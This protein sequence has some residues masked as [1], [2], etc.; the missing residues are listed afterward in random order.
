MEDPDA[1]N[2]SYDQFPKLYVWNKD[3]RIWTKRKKSFSNIIGR[4]YFVPPNAGEL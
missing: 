3:K 2:I 1:K 4:I